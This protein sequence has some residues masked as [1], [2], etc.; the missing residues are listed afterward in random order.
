MKGPVVHL[1][2]ATEERRQLALQE[3][4]D[5]MSGGWGWEEEEEEEQ[6]KD[7]GKE[8]SMKW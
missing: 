4:S 7:E 3:A 5:T 1:R 2:T 6:E 8:A